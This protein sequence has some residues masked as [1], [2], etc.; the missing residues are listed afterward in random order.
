MDQQPLRVPTL[1]SRS[2]AW[3]VT[4]VVCG[5]PDPEVL[6]R[7]DAMVVGTPQ[8]DVAQLSTWA[9]LRATVGYTPLYVLVWR[10]NGL[11]AGAQ[12]LCR[13]FPVLGT[14]GYLPYGPVIA[15]TAAD[16]GD[17][18][19][20]LSGALADIARRRLRMLFVQ[21]LM[22]PGTSAPN[23]SRAGSGPPAPKWHPRVHYA[24]ISRQTRRYS[25]VA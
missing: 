12:I 17:V 22:A 24:S 13:R 9:R 20:E 19:R 8:A 11:V 23:C 21:P 5:D 18:C 4:V 16:R 7:W 1:V 2:V 10:G 14:V 15:P 25:G 6:A 3:P